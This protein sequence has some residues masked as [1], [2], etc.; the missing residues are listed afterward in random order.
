[1]Q[2]IDGLENG[3]SLSHILV[4]IGRTP[5]DVGAFLESLGKTELNSSQFITD[6]A[7]SECHIE[8]SDKNSEGTHLNVGPSM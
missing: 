8:T 7:F 1:M 4:A 6:K 2:L 5:P 3:L